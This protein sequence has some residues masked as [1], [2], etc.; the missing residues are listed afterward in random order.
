[1]GIGIGGCFCCGGNGTFF[2]FDRREL[3]VE[4]DEELLMLLIE[5]T[6][7]LREL[8]DPGDDGGV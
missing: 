5:Q 6:L 2:W 7:D 3:F 4:L 8:N 1:M